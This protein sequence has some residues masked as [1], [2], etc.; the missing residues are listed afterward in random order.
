MLPRLRAND[1]LNIDPIPEPVISREKTK[2]VDSRQEP[3][4]LTIRVSSL[5]NGTTEFLCHNS[6]KESWK[7]ILKNPHDCMAVDIFRKISKDAV[8][9]DSLIWK[10]KS[11]K[12][13]WSD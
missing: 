3:E 8:T 5:W 7:N 4:F 13:G 11:L 12:G 9:R 1:N 6:Y 2:V 10:S